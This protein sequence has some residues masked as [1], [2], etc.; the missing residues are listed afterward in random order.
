MKQR[1]L[2]H[3]LSVL[4]CTA[5]SK[6]A[7]KTDTADSVGGVD[8]STPSDSGT[9]PAGDSA[10]LTVELD[11]DAV[12][13]NSFFSLTW[14]DLS[15]LKASELI[16]GNTLVQGP[17]VERSQIFEVPNPVV[18]ELQAVDTE[19]GLAVAAY[20]G[21]VHRN[22]ED[23][24]SVFFGLGETW[25]LFSNM[26][27]PSSNISEGWNFFDP[28]AEIFA[29]V[30]KLQV[31][32]NLNPVDVLSIS[33]DY[34]TGSFSKERFV[35]IPWAMKNITTDIEPIWDSLLPSRWECELVDRPPEDHFFFLTEQNIWIAGEIPYSYV[36]SDENG[37]YNPTDVLGSK[38]CS[39]EEPVMTAF[40]AEPTT[41]ALAMSLRS[42]EIMP[43]WS[44]VKLFE[45]GKEKAISFIDEAAYKSLHISTD[46]EFAGFDPSIQ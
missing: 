33:G 22:A 15:S 38:T 19:P 6:G 14:V 11:K 31:P 35:M 39:G 26:T 44:L 4:A 43:G 42:S 16:F 2:L 40:I 10:K 27:V 20:V 30:E 9:N 46:C 17:I 7:D 18:E 5:C 28:L 25:M 29:P 12:D 3:L 21:S 23:G 34:I 32:S 24:T 36:D 37:E 41:L 13:E 1:Q 8:S 45:D